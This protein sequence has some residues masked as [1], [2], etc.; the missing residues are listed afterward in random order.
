MWP[1]VPACVQCGGLLSVYIFYTTHTDNLSA[2]SALLTTGSDPIARD[3]LGMTREAI[4]QHTIKCHCVLHT[5][6]IRM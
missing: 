4:T 1:G 3:N 5:Y 2:C 6:T